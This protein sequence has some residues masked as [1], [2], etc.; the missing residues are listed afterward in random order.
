MENSD[1]D[2]RIVD[3]EVRMAFLERTL[4]D[5]DEVVRELADEL[6][7]VRGTLSELRDRVHTAL[8]EDPSGARFDL[9]DEKPPHY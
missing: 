7:R 3:L 8:D 1:A 2:P 6:G 9:A 5:L 4:G